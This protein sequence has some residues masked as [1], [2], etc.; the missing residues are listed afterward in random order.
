MAEK[1]GQ[2]A[3]TVR[4]SIDDLPPRER[5]NV[6]RDYVG[7]EVIRVD[8]E[9]TDPDAPLHYSAQARSVPGAVWGT[10]RISQVTVERTNSLLS[11]GCD[12]IMVAVASSGVTVRSPSGPDLEVAPGA[13]MVFS[14]ARAQRVV[15]HN[16]TRA[17]VLRLPRQALAGM[18]PSLEEA[19]TFIIPNET[20]ALSL[21]LGYAGLLDNDALATPAIQEM[22]GRHLQEMSALL[23]G[24]SPEF[25]D[26][27]K[28]GTIAAA[29]LGTI[30]AFVTANLENPTLNLAITAA[31][32]GVTPRYVQMLFERD[33]TSFTEFL[34]TSRTAQAMRLLRDPRTINRTILSIALECGFSE[35][36]ALNRAFRQHYEMTP[37]DARIHR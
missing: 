14:Q 30:K 27:V 5:V 31:R 9:P 23:L 36:S 13:A 19:P 8:I 20:P 28:F 12:D 29:R 34:R 1:V 21:L 35:A 6:I 11:D 15:Y 32:H 16:A 26:H 10:S 25:Q 22:T 17:W 33:G 2:A 3:P 18:V 4:L 37:T 7:R 24:A